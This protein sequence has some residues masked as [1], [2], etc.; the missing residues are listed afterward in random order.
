MPNKMTIKQRINVGFILAIAFCL[1]LAS[2]RLNRRSY[3]IL[4]QTVSSVYED[5]LVA[6]EY[7]Y[8]LNN[9]FH[10]KEMQFSNAS[11]QQKKDVVTDNIN[12]IFND[13]ADTEL[14]AKELVY[15]TELRNNFDQLQQLESQMADESGFISQRNKV[16]EAINSNLD[17]L[18]E[19]QLTEAQQ[20]THRSQKSLKVSK[21]LSSLEIGFLTVIGIL[22]LF[23]VFYPNKRPNWY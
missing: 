21:L 7:I 8:Q 16:L 10:D 20:L 1:V 6:Q 14:T 2:N 22:F 17:E 15:F 19:V 5:R 4:E 18:A 9:L 11:L 3:N 23:I 12:Q 13:F